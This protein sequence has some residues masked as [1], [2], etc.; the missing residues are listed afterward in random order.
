MVL[1][2]GSGWCSFILCVSFSWVFML[3]EFNSVIVVVVGLGWGAGVGVCLVGWV[4]C[5]IT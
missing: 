1:R 4:E 5:F 2:E 3:L